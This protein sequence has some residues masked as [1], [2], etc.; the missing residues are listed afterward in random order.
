MNRHKYEQEPNFLQ[1]MHRTDETEARNR[2]AMVENSNNTKRKEGEDK[3]R[4][5]SSKVRG[6]N[7]R[8]A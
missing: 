3:D 8:T 5:N 7:P 6:E 1:D 4:R 2:K